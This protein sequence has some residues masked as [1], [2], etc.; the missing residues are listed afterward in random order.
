MAD[1]RERFQRIAEC[2]QHRQ[3]AVMAELQGGNLQ[4]HVLREL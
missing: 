1:E 3:D 2:S 4:W